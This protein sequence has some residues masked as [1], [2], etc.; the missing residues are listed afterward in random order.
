[1]PVAVSPHPDIAM[2]DGASKIWRYMDFT[3]FVTL[4]D[5]QALY[6]RRCDGYE[7]RWEGVIPHQLLDWVETHAARPIWREGTSFAEHFR[8]VEIPRHFMNCW[9]LSEYESAAMWSIYGRSEKAIAIQSTVR[10]FH[11]CLTRGEFAGDRA[12]YVP[13]KIGCVRYGD[14]RGWELPENTTAD[15]Y[16]IPFFF[17]RQ[18]YAYEQEFRAVIDGSDFNPAHTAL[19][20]I[21]IRMPLEELIRQI[22]IAPRSPRWFEELVLSV[23][24]KLGIRN[25]AELI[26]HTDLDSDAYM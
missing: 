6:F 11:R 20:G 22:Y 5:K 2:P 26:K 21:Q 13:V 19:E 14:H 25:A 10:D 3:S 7:D 17:K 8:T 1:M 4:L 15:V 16:A 18:S 23:S 9:H 12:E 24:E